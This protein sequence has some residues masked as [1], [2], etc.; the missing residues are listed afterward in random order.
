MYNN[1]VGQRNNKANQQF[2]LQRKA[3]G[4]TSNWYER[5]QLKQRNKSDRE[6]ERSMMG[7]DDGGVGREGG[8]QSLYVRHR[9]V[10]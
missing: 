7:L 8:T 5:K 6:K 4:K 1:C 2:S 3:M 10:W 9:W